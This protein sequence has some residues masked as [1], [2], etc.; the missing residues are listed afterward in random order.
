MGTNTQTSKTSTELHRRIKCRIAKLLKTN[1]NV[2]N[3]TQFFAKKMHTA[4]L[5][6]YYFYSFHPSRGNNH[7][8][9]ASIP[10]G[11]LDCPGTEHWVP[12]RN[13][14]NRIVFTATRLF[15]LFL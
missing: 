14:G 15:C 10:V 12:N 4:K 9:T 2:T 3:S 5:I 8:N 11:H 7:K 6:L 1:P 13:G